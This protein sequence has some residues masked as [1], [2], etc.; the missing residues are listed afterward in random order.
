MLQPRDEEIERAVL[1]NKR[2]VELPMG[3]GMGVGNWPLPLFCVESLVACDRF[4]VHRYSHHP[5]VVLK[6]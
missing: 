4:W 2:I 1:Q 6:P 3:H 5:K